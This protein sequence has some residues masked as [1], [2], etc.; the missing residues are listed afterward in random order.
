MEE[1]VVYLTLYVPTYFAY[2]ESF[3][4]PRN[5]HIIRILLKRREKV[6][7]RKEATTR[8]R[9]LC[10]E[11]FVSLLIKNCEHLQNYHIH[12]YLLIMWFISQSDCL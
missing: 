11:T 7:D 10:F 9:T 8:Q 1:S 3:T 2:P 6:Y 4:F 5:M 12:H